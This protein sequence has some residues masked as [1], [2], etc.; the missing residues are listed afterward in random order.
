MYL[1]VSCMYHVC[2]IFQNMHSVKCIQADTA[3]ICICAYLYVYD[4]SGYALHV[5]ACIRECISV[6]TE[7]ISVCIVCIKAVSACIC[8]YYL[9]LCQVSGH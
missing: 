3:M 5:S 2:I 8:M 9:A 4:T 7:C 1:Y 6:C